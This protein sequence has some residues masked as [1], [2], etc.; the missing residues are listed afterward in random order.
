MPETIQY[1]VESI[2]HRTDKALVIFRE[3]RGGAT[4]E[5][6]SR[7][8]TSAGRKAYVMAL[9]SYEEAT[10]LQKTPGL[11][12]ILYRQRGRHGLLE[13][14]TLPRSQVWQ[15]ITSHLNEIRAAKKGA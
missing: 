10:L 4:E 14:M 7:L 1:Y 6:F 11:K 9:E 2:D 8:M 3:A 5:L 12:L 13:E 15:E